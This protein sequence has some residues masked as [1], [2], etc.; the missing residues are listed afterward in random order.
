MW[1]DGAAGGAQSAGSEVLGFKVL[2]LGIRKHPLRVSQI[3]C[4]EGQEH[5]TRT[6]SP[7]LVVRNSQLQLHSRLWLFSFWVA[8]PSVFPV[9]EGRPESEITAP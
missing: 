6:G 4:L 7:S 9:H 2:C 1:Q 8:F 3:L 5:E